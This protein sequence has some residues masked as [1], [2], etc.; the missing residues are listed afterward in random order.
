MPNYTVVVFCK[1]QDEIN[2]AVQTWVNVK[3][4]KRVYTSEAGF[5][6]AHFYKNANG[7]FTKSSHSRSEEISAIVFEGD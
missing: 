1:D 5:E 4:Y 2:D 6:A 3:G 7:D